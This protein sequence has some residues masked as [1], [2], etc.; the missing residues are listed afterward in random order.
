MGNKSNI[1]FAPPK[2]GEKL[3]SYIIK[4]QKQFWITAITGII[5]NTAIVLGPIFQGKLLDAAISSKGIDDI[6]GAGLQFIGVT[7]GFQIA[8]FF[9][10]Y[11]VRNMANGISGDMRIGIMGSILQDGLNNVEKQKI[12][13]MMSKTIGDVDIVV[14]AVRKTITELWDTWV[15]MI[16][17]FVT[18]MIYDIRIT[19]IASIP[20]PLVIILAQRMKKVVS[21]KAKASRKANGRTTNQI[22]KMISEINILRLFG[23]EEGELERLEEKLKIQANKTAVA[24][25][26]KNGLAPL[27]ASLATVGILIVIALGGEKVINESWSIGT[28]TAYIT[29]FL[30]LATR[31]TTAAKVFNIQQGAKASWDRV[32]TLLTN[33]TLQDY[34]KKD[35]LNPHKIKI[36]NLCFKYPTGDRYA[37]EN[38]SMDLSGGMIVGITGAVGSGKTSLALALTGLYDYEG[39]IFLDDVELRNISYEDKLATITY[40]GHDSFLFSKSLEENITWGNTNEEK[41]DDILK[42]VALKQDINIFEKGIKTEVGEKGIKVS[43]GQR[44]RIAL[45]RALYK[46][47]NIVIL[48]DPFSAIDIGTEK[49]II[50]ELR[51]NIQNRTIFIF[52]HRLNMFKYTDEVIVLDKGKI[53]ERGTHEELINSQGIYN[54]IIDSQSF[55]GD[56]E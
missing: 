25:V 14:E 16:A 34:L 23:R 42:M 24:T 4:Y 49:K 6:V 9:K 56:G 28:F 47:A 27:Y 44:Q 29:M 12:G 21:L 41:L 11:Y 26:L 7:L 45:A 8:R 46:D 52:S 20:I 17:Y 35:S 22:R 13:D 18:L 15:L 39:D 40:M 36:K 32:K 53:V 55:I 3:I 1:I 19:L 50:Q 30:S 38:L 37:V 5:F 54:K 48:D 43:G 51:K 33:N 2:N 31:T 10:R